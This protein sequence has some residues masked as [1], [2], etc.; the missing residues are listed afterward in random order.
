MT[1]SV[2]FDGGKRRSDGLAL[3]TLSGPQIK[4]L[5]VDLPFRSLFWS[6]GSPSLEALDLL[7]VAGAC[8]VVDKATA[9]KSASDVWTRDLSVSFPVSDPERW[10]KLAPRF[11]TALS[12]L[13]G[14]VWRT[15]FRKSPCDLFV[16]PE[17][18]AQKD[19]DTGRTGCVRRRY[20]ILWWARFAHWG[21][22]LSTGKPGKP[23]YVDWAL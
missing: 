14:D 6:L 15:S 18:T 10:E 1:I 22:R 8:Y 4:P 9:R 7:L 5:E 21:Y 17:D 2:D 11:D 12:F 3:I 20:L 19:A 13:S 23:H 16:A